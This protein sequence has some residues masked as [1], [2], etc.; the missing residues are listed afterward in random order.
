MAT[1]KKW[2][3]GSVITFFALAGICV[4]LVLDGLDRL[5]D[6]MCTTTIFHQS[7][8]LNGKVKAVLYQV[9]CGATTGFNRHV[10]VV[11][12]DTD[13]TKKNPGLGSSPFALRGMPEVKI[14][15]LGSYR[16]EIQYPESANVI[17]A[18][19][20]SNGVAIEYKR[21]R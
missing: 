8:S 13:L 17:R 11:S 9:D 4:V 1:W 18:E 14:A 16:L 20:K 21:S 19:S 3:I 12:V 7:A 10:S 6:E 5:S 15:W 2:I